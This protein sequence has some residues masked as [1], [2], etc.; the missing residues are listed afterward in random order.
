MRLAG[1]AAAG[2]A[3]LGAAGIH[4][5]TAGIVSVTAKTPAGAAAEDTVIVF[6][7]LE[8]PSTNRG[9]PGAGH[10]AKIDQIDK[11]FVPKVSVIATGTLVSLP[12][13]DSIRHEVYSHS[14][15][16][17]FKIKL[18]APDHH[19]DVLFDKPGL[20]VLGCN[21]HDS[22]VAF[23]VVVDS[24]YFAKIL[25]S[26]SRDMNVPAGRYRLRV[27]HPKSRTAIEPR[28]IT[29]GTEPM[30][31]PLIIDLDPSR[32]TAPELPD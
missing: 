10:S 18:Y 19:E 2:L 32:G 27:W 28:E 24:P 30:T 4:A 13:S 17:P 3:L 16:H 8:A 25:A 29:V 7:P 22:M 11:R 20:L 12:N 21:I 14:P 23:V 5:A 9:S 6:D 31:L 26:G 1:R 15:P